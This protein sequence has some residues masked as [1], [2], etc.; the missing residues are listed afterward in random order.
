M[1]A[2]IYARSAAFGN[3]VG[4]HY[5][6]FWRYRDVF[7]ELN[8]ILGG[9]VSGQNRHFRGRIREVGLARLRGFGRFAGL[10][11]LE[12]KELTKKVFTT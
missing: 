6:G 11:P 1:I 9:A 10:P 7:I 5:S 2:R 8:Q 4:L 3:G 12:I